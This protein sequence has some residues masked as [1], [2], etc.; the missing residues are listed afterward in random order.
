[1]NTQQTIAD[2]SAL[3]DRSG[4]EAYYG[5]DVTQ[6]QHALQCAHLAERAKLDDECII[7]ALLHDIGHLLPSDVAEEHMDGY[8]R[9][10]HEK[11]AADYLRE[12]GFS[13]KTA[14]L[15]E[16]HVNAKRYLVARNPDYLA[17]LSDA[18]LQTLTFQG[19]PMSPEE[20]TDFEQNPHFHG[21]LQMRRWDELAKDT[22]AQTPSLTHYL[23]ICERYLTQA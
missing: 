18:S 2:I 9:V 5:E 8:G 7:A 19:G 21:I 12:R 1:M 3:F 10:D 15:I 6:L 17:D 22:D 23:Q 11:L 4:Q 14:Q 20:A 16:H 13:E